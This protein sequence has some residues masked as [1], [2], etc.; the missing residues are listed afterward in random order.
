MAETRD[1]FV[2]E[3]E[4]VADSA[5]SV[6]GLQDAH[7]IVKAVLI[8]V[9]DTGDSGRP[10]RAV[11]FEAAGV[12]RSVEALALLEELVDGLGLVT[13]RDDGLVLELFDRRVDDE[14]RV[15]DFGLIKGVNDDFGV[16]LFAENTVP[17]V[18]G[19]AHDE[20]SDGSFLRVFGHADDDAAADVLVAFDGL[21]HRFLV[22]DVHSALSFTISAQTFSVARGRRI[23]SACS[24]MRL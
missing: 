13:V 3:Q 2:G 22:V 17:A 14:A 11:R 10:V 4:P 7:L 5:F 19:T 8:V 21:A 6:A 18:F 9:D 12:E 15:L 20:V 16:V 24:M 23:H 1:G